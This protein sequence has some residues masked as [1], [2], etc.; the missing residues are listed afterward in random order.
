MKR[1]FYSGPGTNPAARTVETVRRLDNH[2]LTGR[3]NEP[4]ARYSTHLP[5][6]G[7]LIIRDTRALDHLPPPRPVRFLPPLQLEALVSFILPRPPPSR[8]PLKGYSYIHTPADLLIPVYSSHVLVSILN[9]WGGRE[10]IKTY[11][12]IEIVSLSINAIHR[13]CASHVQPIRQIQFSLVRPRLICVLIR[14]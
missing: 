9:R 6:D 5:S 10:I 12:G 8:W 11:N 4:Y 14:G 7:H 1:G 2:N 3:F 13:L